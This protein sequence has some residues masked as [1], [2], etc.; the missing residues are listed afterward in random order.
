MTRLPAEWEPQAGVMLTWP[1]PATDWVDDL[2]AVEALYLRLT[3]LIT[4]REA[5]LICCH[6]GSEAARVASTLAAAGITPGRVHLAV[7][8]SNDTWA[9]DHGPLTVLAD[10]GS[11]RLVD[12]RFNGWGGKYPA[13]LDDRIAARLH[14][15]GLFGAAGLT[16]SR[17]VAE[18]GALECDGA[19]SLLLVR[20]TLLDPARN[21]GWDEAAITAELQRLLGCDRLLWLDRGQ[22]SGD[23]TDGHIDTLARFCA[24]DC[25]CHAVSD[26]ADDPDHAALAALAAELAA[27]RQR[28]GRR[29]RLLPLPQPAPIHAADGRRLPAGYANFLIINGAVLLPVYGDPN[30]AIAARQ[31]AT[32]FPDRQIEPL[33]CRPLIR[34]GGSLHCI[35]MQLPAALTLGDSG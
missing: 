20:R 15:G 12:F 34:Q 4:A 16:S 18:G 14:A 24:P 7:A 27:L 3:A 17:L 22:L 2:T 8:A 35:S 30:D 33:D 31:L 10:D 11:P 29:Y 6:D 26:D 21:P 1:H 19:G 25:I 9:R 13:D 32:A 5:V 28:D 23:D